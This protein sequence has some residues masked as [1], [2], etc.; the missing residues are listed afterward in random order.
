[1]NLIKNKRDVHPSF[2]YYLCGSMYIIPESISLK[3]IKKHFNTLNYN[4]SHFQ[5]SN[6]ICTPIECVKEMVD[7]IPQSFWDKKDIKIL[8]GCCG[9]GNFHAYIST[10]TNI[11][12]LYFNEINSKRIANVKDYFGCDINITQ[13][14]FLEYNEKNK[15]DLVVSNPP[16]AKFTDGKRTS[17]NHNLSRAFISKSLKIT[18]EGGFLLFIV[19]NNWMSFSDR[20]I[21]P[22]ELSK[23]Q[24]HHLNINGA[25]KWFPK[26]GSS[27]TWFLLQKTSNK[28][29]F[30]VSNHYIIKD[31]QTIKLK[32]NI[33]F[34]PLYLSNTSNNI[35]DKVV[36]SKYKKYKIE[37]TSDLHKTTK[38][39]FINDKMSNEFKYKLIHTPTKT[40]WSRKP[41]KFQKGYKVFISLTNQYSTFIDDC[42]MTQSIA[43]I[44]C[45]SLKDATQIKKELDNPI[46]K[47]V[48]NL[49]RY[50]NFN[51]IRV[52]QQLSK[53]ENILLTKEE[54]NFITTFNNKYYKKT[55]II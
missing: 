33:N 11:K 50:G 1:M 49:T 14:D 35:I 4:L 13:E 53:L 9:N 24:F 36:N 37:T 32:P 38:K 42:G 16:Y 12:N 8:D 44:R 23:Y 30:T 7:V 20:N 52:L 51:N 5:N 43:F 40:V 29:N 15:F 34:I 28:N 3:K 6:D 41:H 27:F 45:S 48:N 2:F 19:P 54:I 26:V 31:T 25:K 55:D 47:F 17:K 46:Y 10:K 39:E 22:K 18:K 21:L